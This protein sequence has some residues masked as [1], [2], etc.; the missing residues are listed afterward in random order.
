[1][2]QINNSINDLFAYGFYAV[3]VWID[4]ALRELLFA[5][6]DRDPS[7]EEELTSDDDDEEEAELSVVEVTTDS[8]EY[9]ESSDDADFQ[10][11][12]PAISKAENRST[13]V[14]GARKCRTRGGVLNRGNIHNDRAEEISPGKT[15]GMVETEVEVSSTTNVYKCP[16]SNEI[17]Q[18]QRLNNSKKFASQNV[19][20]LKPRLTPY[21]IRMTNSINDAFQLFFTPKIFKI[22]L[23]NSNKEGEIVFKE[24]WA[25][26]SEDELNGFLGLLFLAG[27]YRSAGKATEEL[28]DI[29]DGRQI[30]R[31]VMSR[32]RFHT[33]SRVLRFDDKATRLL[34][35]NND[36]FAP[37]RVVF[38]VWVQ[39]LSNRP[40]ENVTVD[41]QLVL[42][43]GRCSFRQY[44]KSKPA[45][46]GLKL[47]L[48]CDSSTSY[49]LNAQIYTG[50]IHGEGPERNQGQR[51]VHDLVE[52]IK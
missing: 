29:S 13:P 3:S 5:S 35:R 40:Y 25:P 39:T 30:F 32:E 44:I 42:F 43:R 24:K 1:M 41:E 49:V 36:K 2:Q 51:V 17:W 38:D 52:V 4:L 50:R 8:S 10:V 18:K 6:L 22:V 23:T 37:I 11:D 47:W 27:V 33:I 31:S 12:T 15:N 16:K 45:I 9:T 34:K 14:L 48:L 28:W 21:A 20:K 26:I 46:Y 19:M 7:S